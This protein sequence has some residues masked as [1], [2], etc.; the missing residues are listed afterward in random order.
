MISTATATALKR[1]TG[2]NLIRSITLDVQ[3]MTPEAFSPYGEIIGARGQVELDLDGGMASFVAQTVE[4]RPLL[5]SFLGRHQRTEQVFVPMG[6]TTSIIAV[7]PPCENGSAG[8]NV[9]RMAAFLVDG[10][11]AFKLHRGAWHT[12]AFPLDE[13][14]TFMVLDRENTLEEDYDLRDLAATLGV[15]VEIRQ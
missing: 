8:P 14:A 11:T 5:F 1:K 10:S 6:G 7:A 12:S 13:C 2:E 15:V 4:A 3:N 9:E